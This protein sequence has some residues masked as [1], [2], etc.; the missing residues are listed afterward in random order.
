M[1]KSK[2]TFFQV[3]SKGA[4]ADAS[5]LIEPP[6]S[7]GPEVLDAV[8]MIGSVHKFIVSMLD[9][10]VFF[11][12]EVYQAVIGLKSVGIDR[13]VNIHLLPYDRHQRALRAIL[14]NLGI[15]L[16]AAFDQ[17][18]DNVFAPCSAAP[19]PTDPAGP[20]VA[21][22]D[23]NFTDIE[24]TLLLAVLGNPYSNIIKNSINGLS[25]KTGQFSNFGGFNI[26]GKQLYYLPEFGLRNS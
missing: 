13:R 3:Q 8:N 2:F 24:R 6:F 11:V 15:H 19:N 16:S 4:F 17:T 12:T 26:Q 9:P 7:D 21:F 18:E 10:I 1:I 25:G 14:D 5:E 20:K 23:F 22:V